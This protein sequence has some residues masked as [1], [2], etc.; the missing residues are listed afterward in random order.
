MRQSRVCG[1]MMH[2]D[3][4]DVT[5]DV[6]RRLVDDQFPQWR[7]LSLEEVVAEGT[8]NAIFRIGDDLAARFPLHTQPVDEVWASLESEARALRE[9]AACSPFPTPVPVALG[10]PGHGY[11]LPWAVQT[12]LPGRVASH[13]DP[14][15]SVAFAEDLAGFIACLRATDTQGRPFS[16]RGRGGHLPDHDGWM[17]VCFER[18][19][20]LLDVGRLRRLWGELHVLLRVDPDVMSHKDLIP[21]NVLVR[22]GRLVGVLDGG[23]FGPAD[24]A[25]DLVCAWHLL[26]RQPRAALRSA[27]GC[28]DV[29][30]GRGMAWAF[31]QAM[32]LV[33]YYAGSNPTMSNHGRRTL[34]R[35]LDD[36]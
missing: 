22:D 20:G 18:S 7:R 1:V 26:D 6:V 13:E 28:G 29:E 2:E 15:S 19:E 34:G 35:L 33:W 24:P 9:L 3:Q 5:G 17:D 21:G 12:W 25:L 23:A 10:A 11:P 31:E 36:S 4:V 16:G 14:G 8:D 27:L 32:G 30:W